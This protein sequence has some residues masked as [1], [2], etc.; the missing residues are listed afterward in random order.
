MSAEGIDTLRA[1][2]R[3]GFVRATDKVCPPNEPFLDEKSWRE[4][5][6]VPELATEFYHFAPSLFSPR[7][8]RGLT[9]ALSV[10]IGLVVLTCIGVALFSVSGEARRT[11]AAITLI[12]VYTLHTVRRV[13]LSQM[14]GRY[15][16]AVH[17]SVLLHRVKDGREPTGDELLLEFSEWTHRL[18]SRHTLYEIHTVLELLMA[19]FAIVCFL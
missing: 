17:S 11:F 6:T 9:Y 14:R 16:A 10:T 12:V 1:L 13:E 3:A 2:A 18:D 4:A 8:R 5:R 15:E 19:L 7:V